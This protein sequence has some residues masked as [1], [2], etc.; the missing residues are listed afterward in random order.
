MEFISLSI[1][2]VFFLA[3][4]VFSFWPLFSVSVNSLHT[5]S[6]SEQNKRISR[7]MIE[8]DNI[9]KNILEVRFDKAMKKLSDEDYSKLLNPLNEKALNV[10]RRLEAL[11]VREGDAIFEENGLSAGTENEKKVRNEI[12]EE[13]LRYRNSSLK[14][15]KKNISHQDLSKK[16]N[17]LSVETL[18]CASCGHSCT[19]EDKFCSHC[20]QKIK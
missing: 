9:Y 4:C 3:A 13:I 14:P 11:G 16:E 6:M 2:F 12:E 17:V 15:D 5:N 8:R 18:F 20:G 19:S 7:L 1:L 10:L